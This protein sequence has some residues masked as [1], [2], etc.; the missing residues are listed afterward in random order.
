MT[1]VAMQERLLELVRMRI[2]NGELSQRHLARITG[3]SQPH[4]HNVL[5]GIRFLSTELADEILH[6]MHLSVTDLTGTALAPEGPCRSVPLLP[7]WLGAGMR[8]FPARRIGG[9]AFLPA[10]AVDAAQ[11]PLA[12]ILGEDPLIAPYFRK[13]DLVLIDQSPAAR[14]HIQRHATYV[15]ITA[16]GPRLRFLRA[17]ASRLYLFPAARIHTPS[18]WE[19][20]ACSP[21][22]APEIVRGRVIW[23]G[24]Q[25][26]RRV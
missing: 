10:Q 16:E 25:A 15:A 3:V 8:E 13:G 26:S 21:P 6:Q 22:A 4:M 9:I 19:S 5:K 17:G 11:D 18:S 14:A 12:A 2:R 1:F 7:G 20:V 24:G 23:S